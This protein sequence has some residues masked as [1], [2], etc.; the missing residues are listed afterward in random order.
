MPVSRI[1]YRN[2]SS[3]YVWVDANAVGI[4]LHMDV[5]EKKHAILQ[6][7]D[8]VGTSRGMVIRHETSEPSDR[9]L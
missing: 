9:P 2:G 6:A 1:R 3:T 5:F 8:L 7:M 4:E